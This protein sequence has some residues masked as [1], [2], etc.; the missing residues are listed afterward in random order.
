MERGPLVPVDLHEDEVPDLDVAVAVGLGRAGRPA[1]HLGPVVVEDL[2][3][4]AARAGVA[5]KVPIDLAANI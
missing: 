3:A 2:R 1:L 5:Q 4:R